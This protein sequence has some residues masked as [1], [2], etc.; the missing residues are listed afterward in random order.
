MEYIGYVM[1][2]LFKNQGKKKSAEAATEA[3]LSAEEKYEANCERER[4]D[5]GGTPY[6]SIKRRD[7]SFIKIALVAVFAATA[8]FLLGLLALG[9]F[10]VVR[11]GGQLDGH[12]KADARGVGTASVL[13][14]IREGDAGNP[15]AFRLVEN[16]DEVDP[17]HVVDARVDLP[18]L[19]LGLSGAY[20]IHNLQ[21]GVFYK[22]A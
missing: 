2:T 16:A 5:F 17:L 18:V 4:W 12:G 11:L 14:F 19:V 8:F 9:F 1:L 22:I 15:I 21:E 6:G 20:A 10:A 13:D 7:V 3:G